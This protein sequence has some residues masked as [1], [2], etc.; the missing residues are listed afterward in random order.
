M[1]EPPPPRRVFCIGRNYAAHVRELGETEDDQCVVFM[2][3]CTSL[4][5]IGTPIALPRARGAVHH[6]LELVVALGTGGEN[7]PEERAAEHIDAITLG[8]DLT[9]RDLQNQLKAQGRPWELCKAFEQSA[10]IG[11]FMPYDGRVDLQAI[12]MTCHVNGELRQI[13]HTAHMIFPVSWL[14][15]FLSRHWQLLPG[16]LIFTGTPEGV[17]EVRPGDQIVIA[18]PAI[19]QFTWDLV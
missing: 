16:D 8:L 17:G 6:E 12:E 19:G 3:P 13:G 5:T 14:I 10:P 9:L 11:A 18:S 1:H 7:I 4:E 15:S 2:K